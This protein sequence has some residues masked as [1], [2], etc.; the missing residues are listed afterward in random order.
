M[1]QMPGIS[2][3]GFS[4]EYYR[5]GQKILVEIEAVGKLVTETLALSSR[6]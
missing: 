4:A 3:I 5:A 1:P 6:S 2:A